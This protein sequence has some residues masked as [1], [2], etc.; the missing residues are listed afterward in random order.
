M[1]TDVSGVDSSL[2]FTLL[3]RRSAIY[4]TTQCNIPE[5]SDLSSHFDDFETKIYKQGE[6]SYVISVLFALNSPRSAGEIVSLF[7][8]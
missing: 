5:D 6:I 2:I 7:W 3:P 1:F 4:Q 8:V